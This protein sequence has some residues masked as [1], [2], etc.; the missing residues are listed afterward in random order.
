M[1]DL[2]QFPIDRVRASEPPGA[3]APAFFFDVA[4]PFSYLAA[5]D[6]ERRLPDAVWVPVDGAALVDPPARGPGLV[7][8]PAGGPERTAPP[9][10]APAL[11]RLRARANCGCRSSGPTSSRCPRG[12]P[13][14]PRRSPASSAR[15]RRSRSPRDGSRSA[16]ASR[17]RTR[18]RSP[19]R[20]RRPPCRSLRAWRPPANAG[21]TRSSPR[22]ARPCGAPECTGSPRSGSP[23]AGCR[24]SGRSTPRRRSPCAA[25]ALRARSRP[26]AEPA[27]RL[28]P[29][30]DPVDRAIR[31]IARRNSSALVWAQFGI[32]HLVTIAGL[33]LLRLYQPMSLGRFLTIIGVSQALVAL[34]NV[35]SIKLTRRLWRP[36][37]SW[38]RT[39][40]SERT[41]ELT[42]AAW[43][44]LV[45]LPRE[46]V[47]RVRFYPFTLLYLPFIAFTTW[48][49]GLPWYSFFIIAAAGTAVIAYELIARYFAL[50]VVIRP[51]LEPVA[52]AL[53]PE[54]RID[55]GG[56]PL[57][58]RLLAVA[59]VI[60]VITGVV[61]ASLSNQG[62]H[63]DLADLG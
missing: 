3:G 21:A 52:A 15:G 45:T 58:W 43:R 56:L 20:R 46:Y 2:L 8:P 36:V 32:A 34:D 13:G 26:R 63:V 62:H 31:A 6:V 54:F 44:A 49:L 61:V 55:V 38:E 50:E 22:R 53:P 25:R 51:V 5:E 33:G 35:V 42:I 48:L 47:R 24:A 29:M 60:N 14:A 59:P 16:V 23:G 37:G 39:P 40:A 17:S 9:A 41:P 30:K 28:P 57:R 12:A 19:R 10:G 11:A 27:G 18:R 4:C 7:A 1:G